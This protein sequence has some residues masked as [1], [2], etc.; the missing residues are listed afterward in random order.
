MPFKQAENDSFSTSASAPDTS[1]PARS[2]V[3]FINLNFA[4][5]RRFGFTGEGNS[6]TYPLEQSIHGIAV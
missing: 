6:F 3:A 1:D 5:N 4:G 2:E